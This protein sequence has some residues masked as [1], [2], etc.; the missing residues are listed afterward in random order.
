MASYAY[1]DAEFDRFTNA[2]SNGSDFSGNTLPYAPKEKYFLALNHS[3]QLPAPLRL[4]SYLDYGY[5]S[6]VFSNPNNTDANRISGFY[7]LNARISLHHELWSAALW[8]NNL[9]DEDHLKQQNVSFLGVRR[10]SYE[11]PRTYGASLSY[12]FM[13]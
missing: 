1:T 13:R 11:E 5:Q 4:D 3:L 9:T 12:K 8:A 2:D 6:P 10:G 7:T